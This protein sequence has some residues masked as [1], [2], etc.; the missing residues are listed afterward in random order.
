MEGYC[1]LC[2]QKQTMEKA[3]EKKTSN[4]R[5]MMSGICKQCGTKMNV[6]IASG[7]KS[8]SK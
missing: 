1:V 6:F 8:K 5:S 2:K 4:G 7:G 3:Q